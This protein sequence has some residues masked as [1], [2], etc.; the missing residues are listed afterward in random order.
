MISS[1]YRKMLYIKK[2]TSGRALRTAMIIPYMDER[3]I[4]ISNKNYSVG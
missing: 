2:E 4:V 3:R 1:H